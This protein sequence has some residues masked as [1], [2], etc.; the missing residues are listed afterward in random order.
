MH[1]AGHASNAV[2]PVSAPA[3]HLYDCVFGSHTMLCDAPQPP[4]GIELHG[5]VI[6]EHDIESAPGCGDGDGVGCALHDAGH[7]SN[8]VFPVSAPASH[9]YDC[10]FGS[11]TMLCDAPQPP[12]GIELHGYVMKVHD[13]ES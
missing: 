5:Y 7:A 6:K 8:A 11:H 13:V 10:V 4:L 9:L 3:S 12:L 2:F 1:D